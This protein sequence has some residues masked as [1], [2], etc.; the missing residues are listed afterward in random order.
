LVG[1]ETGSYYVKVLSNP[2]NIK[3]FNS[4]TF[5]DDDS[6]SLKFSYP[7]SGI[8]THK[9]LSYS[10]RSGHINPSKA[11][12]KFP[13]N[14]N[15]KNGDSEKTIPG[16]TGM[17]IN[18]VQIYNYKTYDK[19]YYG[20]IEKVTV[21]NGGSDFDV[22]N[23]PLIEVSSGV[24]TTALIQP[25]ITGSISDILVD[26]QDFDINQILSV[27]VTGGNISGGS[28]EPILIKRR[29]EILFDGRS[30]TNGGGISTTTNQ[31]TFLTDHNLFNGEE[32]I[33]RNNGNPN[34]SIGIGLSSLVN[35]S[36]YYAKVDNN[37]T[38]KLFESFDDY[39]DGSKSCRI[40]NDKS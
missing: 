40:C 27:N 34:I 20:P 8:G 26:S 35:N 1:L 33:Y 29:R 32:I 4:P 5:I 15:I 2:R 31:L 39:L 13:L 28:F 9:F 21:L 3:I 12:K 11:L 30:T 38:I 36:S 17:L 14:P 7:L 19:I 24:G 37:S 23:P 18:G 10:Q 16:P 6:N 22:I 25:V